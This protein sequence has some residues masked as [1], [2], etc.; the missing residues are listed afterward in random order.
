M[1]VI[2]QQG[3]NTPLLLLNVKLRFSEVCDVA[4]HTR[5]ITIIAQVVDKTCKHQNGAICAGSFPFMQ[6]RTHAQQSDVIG[7]QSGRVVTQNFASR[8]RSL[9][10]LLHRAKS[11]YKV[12]PCFLLGILEKKSQNDGETRIHT[13][14]HAKACLTMHFY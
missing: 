14:N 10:K 1:K 7:A 6:A 9:R 3:T 12:P 13:V 4:S 8:P 2:A 11:E 5:Y